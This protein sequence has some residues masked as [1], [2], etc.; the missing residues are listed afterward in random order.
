MAIPKLRKRKIVQ[1]CWSCAKACN[2]FKCQWARRC[3]GTQEELEQAKYPD[4]VTTETVTKRGLHRGWLVKTELVEII[5]EC[6]NYEWDG[7]SK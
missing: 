1:K 5:T 2:D 7:K 6:E 4:Y 3:N